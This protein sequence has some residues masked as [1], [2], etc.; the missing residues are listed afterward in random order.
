MNTLQ[1]SKETFGIQELTDF[2]I[3]KVAGGCPFAALAIGIGVGIGLGAL[4][5]LF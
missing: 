4:A 1:H 3:E 2:D 5:S